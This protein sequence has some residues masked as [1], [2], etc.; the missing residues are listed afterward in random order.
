MSRIF[1][2]ENKALVGQL[3]NL[4]GE[5]S[6]VEPK[7]RR[8]EVIHN[9]LQRPASKSASAARPTSSRRPACISASMRRSQASAR[10][11]SNQRGNAASYGAG[12]LV[13]ADSSSLR[14]TIIAPVAWN[15]TYQ[16]SMLMKLRQANQRQA[17]VTPQY[18][19]RKSNRNE[20]SYQPV[21]PSC[22]GAL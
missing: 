5:L 19:N 18:T 20:K 2:Q 6:I 7:S 22:T 9:G 16:Y 1:S 15:R 21:L 8:R 13:M 10:N 12:S 14:L 17:V 11:A 4:V 3:A